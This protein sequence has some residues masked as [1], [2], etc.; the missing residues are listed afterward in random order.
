M[1]EYIVEVVTS[2]V[3]SSIQAEKGGAKRIELCSALA[4]AGVSP[5]TAMLQMVKKYVSIPV[6]VMVRPREGDFIYSDIEKEVMRIEINQAKDNGANGFVLGIL[7]RNGTV[8]VKETKELV[9]Y[10]APLP[11]TFHRAFDCVPNMSEALEAIIETGCTRI[12]TSG[13]KATGPEGAENLFKLHEQAAG[14]ITVMPGGG[15]KPEN[16]SQVFSQNIKEY[17]LSGR[18][19]VKSEMYPTLFEMDYAETNEESVRSVIDYIAS[20]R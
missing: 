10:C 3:Y 4:T 19:I 15:I 7:N 20:N 11:V 12:L 18:T 13:G 9:Q 17:H 14:R 1:S 8:N 2:S 5:N 6:F 16:F